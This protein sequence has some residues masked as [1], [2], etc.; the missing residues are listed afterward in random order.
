MANLNDL[1]D[2]LNSDDRLR[3]DFLANPADVFRREGIDLPPEQEKSLEQLVGRLKTSPTTVPGSSVGSQ[4]RG[5]DISINI[6]KNF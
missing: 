6:S 1:Q 2:R 5:V 3:E 4:E